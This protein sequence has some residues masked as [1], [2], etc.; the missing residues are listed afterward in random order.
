MAR[1]VIISETKALVTLYF[2]FDDGETVEFEDLPSKHFDKLHEM[3]G[4]G[5][6]VN[7]ISCNEI[8]LNFDDTAALKRELEKAEQRL[9]NMVSFFFRMN[10]DE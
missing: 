8:E 6:S 3:K 10:S 5:W 1:S 9:M 2:E 7:E 4:E